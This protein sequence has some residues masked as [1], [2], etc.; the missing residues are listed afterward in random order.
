MS[1]CQQ[2]RKSKWFT[3]F[4]GRQR[5]TTNRIRYANN[6][7]NIHLIKTGEASLK[8]TLLCFLTGKLIASTATASQVKPDSIERPKRQRVPL[9]VPL[10]G[11][12]SPSFSDAERITYATEFTKL[13]NGMRVA[14]QNR[15]GR[16]CTI[17]VAIKAGSRYEKPFAKGISHVAEKLGFLVWFFFLMLYLHINLFPTIVMNQVHGFIV[18]YQSTSR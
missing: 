1:V 18:D 14:S 2:R 7:W 8:M 11:L 5:I 15:P 9:D 4:Q 13:E 10:P 16:Y 12:P 3:I 6:R 17:G